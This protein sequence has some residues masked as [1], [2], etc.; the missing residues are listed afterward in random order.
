[1]SLLP[2]LRSHITRSAACALA[3]TKPD[4]A[5]PSVKRLKAL[6]N[7]ICVLPFVVLAGPP[8]LTIRQLLES[9][10]FLE[11]L[12]LTQLNRRSSNPA[13]LTEKL[14]SE[15]YACFIGRDK[16]EARCG[17]RRFGKRFSQFESTRITAAFEGLHE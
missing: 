2:P 9:A 11:N 16:H 1:M 5:R 14:F 10:G 7:R 6:E 15:I 17:Y 13:E 12:F 8:D 3:T 4:A